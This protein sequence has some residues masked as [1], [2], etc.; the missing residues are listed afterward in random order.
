VQLSL[1]AIKLPSICL[2]SQSA[3]SRSRFCVPVRLTITFVQEQIEK[4]VIKEV[5]KEVLFVLV[6]CTVFFLV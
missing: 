3:C 2:A 1:D 5:I 6:V 4:Q